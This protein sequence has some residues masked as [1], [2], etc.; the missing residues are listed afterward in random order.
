MGRIA[1]IKGTI[2]P[3]ILECMMDLNVGNG[4]I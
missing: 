2:I 3:I 4:D 1:D